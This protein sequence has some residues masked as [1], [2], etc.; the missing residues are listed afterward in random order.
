MLKIPNN[1]EIVDD[2]SEKDKSKINPIMDLNMHWLPKY[3]NVK[4]MKDKKTNEMATGGGNASNMDSI[5][6]VTITPTLTAKKNAMNNRLIEFLSGGKNSETIK[7]RSKKLA[8]NIA[9]ANN[10]NHYQN[11]PLMNSKPNIDLPVKF[12]DS[13]VFSGRSKKVV[14]NKNKENSKAIEVLLSLSPVKKQF[15]P[16]S[17]HPN[18]KTLQTPLSPRKLMFNSKSLSNLPILQI[19]GPPSQL[20]H[21][22]TATD[23]KFLNENMFSLLNSENLKILDNFD[24]AFSHQN[25]PS[26]TDFLFSKFPTEQDLV[27]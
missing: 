16:I 26:K 4:L 3:I 18:Q 1:G 23:N 24:S 6:G 12:G 9:A 19:N 14:T 25:Q 21:S 7:A 15:C 22:P 27:Q 5:G 13:E 8:E 20:Q 11:S 10:P 2:K 17:S